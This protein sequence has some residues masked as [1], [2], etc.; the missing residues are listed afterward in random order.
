M[1]QGSAEWLDHRA[2]HAATASQYGAAIGVG[3]ISRRKYMR[4]KLG[5]DESDP[6]NWRMQEGNRREP[7]IAELYYRIMHAWQHPVQLSVDAFVKDPDD[8]RIGGS[9][10]R[11][12]TDSNND[13]WVLEIK[14]QPDADYV[15][16]EVPITHLLQMLGLCHAYGYDKAH[17]ICSAYGH[18][19]FLAEVTW[20]PGFW[21]TEIYPRLRQFADWWALRRTPP[22]MRSEEKMALIAKI[23]AN[24]FVTRIPALVAPMPLQEYLQIE[25]DR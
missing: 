25:A 2:K 8:P 1:Q 17:Y 23:R 20:R 15:R 24:S 5:I 18:G 11:L 22:I 12:V 16:N 6:P 9:V 3:Y 4:Q 7:H 10:D 21:N 14:T 13:R 19:I